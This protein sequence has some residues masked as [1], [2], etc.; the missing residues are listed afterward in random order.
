M[1]IRYWVSDRQDCMDEIRFL[2]AEVRLAREDA[3]RCRKLKDKYNEEN[4]ELRH[5]YRGLSV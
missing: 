2:R 4:N 3:N 1:T 5:I